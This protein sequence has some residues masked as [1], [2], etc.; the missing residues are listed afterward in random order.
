M[1]G[2]ALYVWTIGYVQVLRNEESLLSCVTYYWA[3]KGLKAQEIVVDVRFLWDKSGGRVVS[4]QNYYLGLMNKKARS[5]PSCVDR[6]CPLLHMN[7]VV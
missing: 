6:V 4:M 2:A 1:Y 7:L 3:Q 5:T